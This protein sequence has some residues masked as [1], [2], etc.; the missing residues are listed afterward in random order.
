[1]AEIIEPKV[2]QTVQPKGDFGWKGTPKE[3]EIEPTI[4]PVIET[5]QPAAAP[6]A[7]QAQT[8]DFDFGIAP[9]EPEVKPEQV[10][11]WK[12]VLK[13]T[14][15]EELYK[16]LGIEDDDEFIKEFKNAR[17]AGLEYKYLEAKTKDWTKVDDASLA[18]QDLASEYPHLD[19]ADLQALFNDKYKQ[20][21]F[22]SEEEKKLGEIKLKADAYK[23][24]QA[25]I[26]EQKKF[27]IPAITATKP[28]EV[29]AQ[30]QQQQ[31]QQIEQQAEQN[32]QR[33]LDHEATKTLL[34]NKKVVVPAGEFGK[35]NIGIDPNEVIGYFN[36]AKTYSK[37][38]L[39]EKG[40][41]DLGK[42]QV[43]AAINIIGIEKF[44]ERLVQHGK[45]L[46][47]KQLLEEGQNAGKTN[48]V[49]GTEKAKVT[50]KST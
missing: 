21:E 26:E 39:N 23:S 2:E 1:M 14:P 48:P 8:F 37:Y 12:K 34:A 19:K 18:L 40:E 38:V 9:T 41:P 44:T 6:A 16:E 33:V 20:D 28:E 47:L 31:Q 50:W 29:I 4:E 25:K 46:G 43:L 35:F 36:D 11:D 3:P 10:T 42:M 22:A 13:S 45:Q 30:Y 17:K 24:R 49:P 32:K 27:T 5:A 7:E 15:K